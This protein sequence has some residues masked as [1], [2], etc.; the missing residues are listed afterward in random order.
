MANRLV[1]DALTLLRSACVRSTRSLVVAG[2]WL[3]RRATWRAARTAAS[4][5]SSRAQ[6][7]RQQHRRDE[8]EQGGS[9]HWH[10]GT[11]H[12]QAQCVPAL[13]VAEERLQRAARVTGAGQDLPPR[14]YAS[15]GL[16]DSTTHHHE[17]I[18]C[19]KPVRGR[20]R[21]ARRG[22]PEPDS[23]VAHGAGASVPAV[24]I[25]RTRSGLHCVRW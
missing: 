21:R 3:C 24:P 5:P 14:A 22:S 25:E 10:A 16:F 11:A 19:G 8:P 17:P 2:S 18:T 7:G 15:G 13:C 4:D 1:L 9:R 20:G 6:G 23:R 12:G